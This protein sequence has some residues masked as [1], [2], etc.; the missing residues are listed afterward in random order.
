MVPFLPYLSSYL[1]P[2]LSRRGCS[3]VPSGSCDWEGWWP[4]R[5]EQRPRG[6]AGSYMTGELKRGFHTVRAVISCMVVSSVVNPDLDT[7]SLGSL[8]PYPD[9]DSQSEL[10]SG[11][12][13]RRA[14]MTHI[15]RKIKLH[16][17]GAGCSLLRAEG[18]SCSLDVLYGG[19]GISK[20]NFWPKK[21]EKFF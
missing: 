8:D 19:L 5:Q 9:L 18:F 20:C 3:A 16:F 14:K 7:D 1:E 6:D 12:R 4:T 2:L 13:S 11:S 15:C 10:R 21:I 17:W